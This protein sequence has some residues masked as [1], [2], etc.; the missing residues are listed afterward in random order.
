[1][2]ILKWLWGSVARSRPLIGKPRVGDVELY[3][4]ICRCM[5]MY[6]YIYISY[7]YTYIHIYI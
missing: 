1:M 2:G 3:T 7:T 4:F 5:Y 6:I